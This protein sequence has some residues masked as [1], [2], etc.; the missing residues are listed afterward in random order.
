MDKDFDFENTFES[1]LKTSKENFIDV[2]ERFLRI[3]IY[4]YI[5]SDI[6]GYNLKSEHNEDYERAKAQY[7][8]FSYESI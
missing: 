8:T 3:S 5:Y 7:S 6:L 1:L 2:D 4:D